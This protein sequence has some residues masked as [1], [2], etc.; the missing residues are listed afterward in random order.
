M[1]RLTAAALGIII[2]LYS[3]AVFADDIFSPWA[4]EEI[5][6]AFDA[7]V[8]PNGFSEEYTG[9]ITRAEFARLA[10]AFLEAVN[11]GEADCNDIETGVF[12]DTD[13]RYILAAYSMGII[14]GRG[15]GTF[16]PNDY[17]TRQEA[18]KVIRN[19]YAAYGADGDTDN[20]MEA[21][22]TDVTE[23]ADWA[24]DDIVYVRRWGVMNG[25]DDGSF[26]PRDNYT[27]EQSLA[28]FTRLYRRIK[29][30]LSGQSG[31]PDGMLRVVNGRLSNGKNDVLLNGVNLGGWLIMETWMSP[32]TDPNEDMAYSDV[33]A[34]LNERFGESKSA[35]LIQSYEDSYITDEDFK[36][37]SELGF[38]CIRLPFW[39]R[40]FMTENYEMLA[41][42]NDDNTGFKR[43]DWVIEQCQKYGIYLI[44]DMHGCPGGQ[45][46]NHSTGVKGSNRLYTDSKSLDAMEK[47]WTEIA[48]RYSENPYVAA[49]DIMNEPQNNSG[50]SGTRA[51][52]AGSK[53]AVSLTNSVYDRMIKAI[54]RVDKNHIITVEGIWSV[55][56]LPPPSE[57]GWENMMYQLHIYDD[58]K[59]MIDYRIRELVRA[60]SEYGTAVL[61]GEYN[62]KNYQ[63]YALSGYDR[64][65][66][67]HIKWTYKTVGVDYD[68]WG[69]Y[70]KNYKK[71]D[72]KTASYDE[73]AA[74]FGA[75]VR[76]YNGFKLNTAYEK[77]K[78]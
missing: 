42:N 16:A 20:E 30:A 64:N 75:D 12:S 36:R 56:V 68:N 32:I 78:N 13:D 9:N 71:I 44:L 19:T 31:I 5:E 10:V 49:Y 29:D 76:T 43:L 65:G 69:I 2:L 67:S 39:Y 3:T 34:I 40:N 45:S 15:D 28:S 74:A 62:N 58:N 1:K 14:K 6:A 24:Y 52:S 55:S 72:I 53:T 22:Y 47:L 18:A 23:I 25:M 37:I 50:Y 61:V 51:W 57:H 33:T 4:R 73:I 66:I 54:R 27:R 11:G 17:I 8:V 70:N 77:I 35:E 48:K 7:G 38:N 41:P 46:M 59:E 60:R 63:K 21:D 26:R